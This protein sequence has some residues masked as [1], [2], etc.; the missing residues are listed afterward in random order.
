M[1]IT[2]DNLVWELILGVWT[3]G[4][5]GIIF[6][7]FEHGKTVMACYIANNNNKYI[8]LGDYPSVERAKEV[9]EAFDVS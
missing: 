4:R 6:Q 1:F 3:S 5:G 7:V 2:K 8:S 9:C